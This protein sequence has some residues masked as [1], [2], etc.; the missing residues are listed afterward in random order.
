MTMVYLGTSSVS[1][2]TG[3]SFTLPSGYD[4]FEFHFVQFY[5]NRQTCCYTGLER[6][7][8]GLNFAAGSQP[9]T[10]TVLHAKNFNTDTTS[11]SLIYDYNT[12]TDADNDYGRQQVSYTVGSPTS[13]G[14]TATG[15]ITL[16]EPFS[17]TSMKHFTTRAQSQYSYGGSN[18]NNSIFTSVYYHTTNPV[19]TVSFGIS[20][21]W[22]NKFYGDFYMYGIK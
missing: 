6:M 15:V 18:T 21:P 12:M 9:R 5:S 2:V 17:T 14:P 22:A 20:A 7:E 8:F 10:S 1:G 13:T 4:I 19:S 3:T 16:Y 11:A